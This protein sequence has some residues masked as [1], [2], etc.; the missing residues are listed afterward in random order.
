[1]AYNH[2]QVGIGTYL[3]PSDLLPD[4]IEYELNLRKINV[5]HLSLEDRRLVLRR[6]QL[7]EMSHPIVLTSQR[8]MIQ[9]SNFLE[10]KLVDLRYELERH[11][12]RTELLTRLR[13]I[14]LRVLRT[15]APS[16]DQALVKNDILSEIDYYFGVYASPQARQR[17]NASGGLQQS[18]ASGQSTQTEAA[19][20][21]GGA[22]GIQHGTGSSSHPHTNQTGIAGQGS[23]NNRYTGTVPRTNNRMLTQ[24]EVQR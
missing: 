5:S 7:A 14:R 10:A 21:V 24:E 22:Q 13:H 23:S 20:A 6:A 17:M 3:N 18:N 12:A 4:E 1:M 15:E 11:G 9:D 16:R 2:N 8:T 19:G